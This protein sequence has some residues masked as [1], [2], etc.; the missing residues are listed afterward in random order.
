MQKFP[1]DWLKS[2][3]S[4]EEDDT[5]GDDRIPLLDFITDHWEQIF[6]TPLP[7]DEI[8]PTLYE[9]IDSSGQDQLN[10]YLHRALALY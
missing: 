8:E 4:T 2:L 5:L 1:S 10:I 7:D 6:N 3:F 9:I